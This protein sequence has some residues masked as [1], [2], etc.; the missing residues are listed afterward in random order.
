MKKNLRLM[1][2]C[3]VTGIA[4]TSILADNAYA[5]AAGYTY[6]PTASFRSILQ[7]KEISGT[8][9]DSKGAPLPGVSVQVKGTTKGAQTNAN[10]QYH[11]SAK[12]G[13]VL[14][15][16]SIG[17]GSH[18]AVV[19]NSA[20]LDVKLDDNVK[21]LNELVV[22]ALGVKKAA[23]SLTYSTQRLGNEELT[24]AKDANVMNS[25]SGKAAGITISKS[26]SGVG[27]SVKV[28]LRG[29]KSAQGTNQPLYVIDG[30]PMTNYSTQ[31]PNSTWGGDGT[32]TFTPGRDGG[33]GISNLNP[34]DIES[35]SVLKG[36][37]ASALYG[38]QAANGVI[39]ITTK[40]GKAGNAKVEFSSGFTLDKVAYKPELQ[41]S[42]GATKDGSTQSWGPAITNA[43]DNVS[44]FFRN[45]NTWINSINFTAGT[46]KAQ[47]Y[48]SYANT[49]AKAVMPGNDLNRHNFSFRETAKFLNDKL[50]LDGNV[51]IIS[52]KTDNGPVTGLYFNPLTGLYLFPRGR[53][54]S[55]Y[56][57]YTKFDPI[58]QIDLQNWPFNEDVQQ[59][60]Y[61]IINK[62]NSQAV[63]NRTLFNASAKYDFNDWL[64]LQARGNM[65]RTNDTY[66][67]QFYA[68]T[69]PVLS[70]ANGRYIMSDLTTTQFYGDLILNLNRNLGTNFKLNALVGTSINDTR[71]KG[72]SGDS[73]LG[74]LYVANKFILQNMTAGSLIQTVPENHTQLQAVF[75]NVN[76]SYKDLVFLDLSGRNDW[77]SNLSFT[78]NGSYFYPSA[79]LSF[80][81]HQLFNLPE[82]VSY[83]KLRGSY[84][85]VGNTVPLYV[86]NPLSRLGQVGGTFQFNNQAPFTDLKPERTKSLEIGTEWRFLQSRLNFD[87]TYY[88]TNTTNQYFQIAVPPGTGYSFRFINAGNI[89]NSGFEVV[90]GYNV[91]QSSRF[92]WNTSVNYSQN[93]NKVIELADNIDQFILTP[94]G[95]NTFGSIIE[96][97]GSYGDIFGK[98]LKRDE[99]GRIIIGS[100]GTPLVTSDLVYVGNANPKWQ[101]G[102]SN[103]FT[104]GNFNLSFLV[105]G[106]FGGKVM[107]QTEAVMD[108]YGVSARTGE[109]R[110]AGGVFING[111]SE[112]TKEPVTKVDA[113]KWYGTVGGRDGVSG[114]YM[115]DATVVRLRELSLG[116]AIPSKALGHGFVKNIRF[117][118][119]GRNL[120]YISKKAPFDPEIA[121]STGNGLSGVDMFG[122]PATRSF[123]FNLNVGF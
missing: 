120:W 53:D 76:L 45:G 77:S 36:A 91:I 1:K 112:A 59:N 84:A 9:R 34:D 70:G 3:A 25:I 12:A 11:L 49:N 40:K 39:L 31:Q 118:L 83:A 67:G 21:G 87:F 89:Q 95:S 42:Y 47:S 106:K 32:S 2:V 20:T 69:N 86:T 30:I 52:Q 74:D 68:G 55:P 65:D 48:F 123:G 104:Y 103:R 117:S 43:Q 66:D 13:D 63:R 8:V 50:T 81:L 33:D 19:G 114:E 79:G 100:D 38:S 88:K 28:T 82:P 41:N 7:E 17:F 15:F 54:L 16:S 44:D 105:D 90:L 115:Y 46:E 24:T 10:G 98:A 122:L 94:A 93:K 101:A 97:G 113:D 58:R 73:Y 27:G 102:W 72:M 26:G 64:Y 116:Y 61:W 56:K 71:T 51:N 6:A 22:T 107:S 119:V 78:P 5:K 18:E 75:G 96:K 99:S 4:L 111:V 92:T 80:M 109:A 57:T 37:S 35:V 110:K 14:V 62:N 121:M 60:P 23:K 29:N 108:K 85:V